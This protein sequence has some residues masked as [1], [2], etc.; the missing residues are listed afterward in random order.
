MLAR[1]RDIF[2]GFDQ[3]GMLAI[4]IAVTVA[5]AIVACVIVWGV[6]RIYKIGLIHRERQAMIDR[7]MNPG[8]FIEDAREYKKMQ[9]AAKG[10]ETPDGEEDMGVPH[11][12]G[13][14]DAPVPGR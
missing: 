13:A 6:C 4:S 9:E 7:G 3:F 2:S 1:S 12:H 5:A 10:E 8:P 14:D 11:P